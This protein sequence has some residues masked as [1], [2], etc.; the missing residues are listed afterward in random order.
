M[1]GCCGVAEELKFDGHV[2]TGQRDG[3]KMVDAIEEEEK[4]MKNG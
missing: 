4:G 3:R 1:R 2:S